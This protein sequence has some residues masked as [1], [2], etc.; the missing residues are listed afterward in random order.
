MSEKIELDGYTIELR[1]PDDRYVLVSY[2][3]DNPDYVRTEPLAL[4]FKR[5][6]QLENE[7]STLMNKQCQVPFQTKH[8][9]GPLTELLFDLVENDLSMEGDTLEMSTF[10]ALKKAAKQEAE[11][12]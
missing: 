4:M 3:G 9:W 5:I 7:W 1:E 12:L 2:G 6:K 10:Q 11:G 8:T